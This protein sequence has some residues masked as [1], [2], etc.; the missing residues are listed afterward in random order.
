[1]N[2]E[3]EFLEHQQGCPR[4]TAYYDEMLVF[5][6]M[7]NRALAIDVPDARYTE[8][9]EAPVKERV[10]IWG[11]ARWYALAA[12]LV[13]SVGAASLLM[14]ARSGQ[15][16]PE[17]L[18]AHINHEAVSL[19]R[20]SIREDTSNVNKIVA[21]I[22]ARLDENV[23]LVS[24][25]RTCFFRG[26]FVPHLVVQGEAGPVTILILPNEEVS[27]PVR[28]DEGG[29]RGTILPTA[30]GSIAVIGESDEPM[31]AIENRV[32]EAVEWSI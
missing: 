26:Y 11:N 24:Y 29:F 10:R 1:M 13:L 3:A 15:M 4:C 28:F 7:L 21:K 2:E 12:T 14:F 5:E 22:G 17:E 27:A 20:T 23:G 18:I 16:S 25:A 31:E 9:P 8:M 32:A 30:R 19:V 6:D